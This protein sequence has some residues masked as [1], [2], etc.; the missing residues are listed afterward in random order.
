[1]GQTTTQD[2]IYL[3]K[4][5]SIHQDS[6]LY[7]GVIGTA[8]VCN[9][10]GGN[11]GLPITIIDGTKL[12][13]EGA[14]I[15]N[16]AIYWHDH[17]LDNI[18]AVKLNGDELKYG[19]GSHRYD[20]VYTPDNTYFLKLHNSIAEV[21]NTIQQLNYI[22]LVNNE[23]ISTQTINQYIDNDV[24][25]NVIIVLNIDKNLCSNKSIC[26]L[27][28]DIIQNYSYMVIYRKIYVKYDN[29]TGLLNK[30][31]I[32][33]TLSQYA[34]KDTIKNGVIRITA[35]QLPDCSDYNPYIIGNF[36][37]SDFS[38]KFQNTTLYKIL[39][40]SNIYKFEFDML[41]INI[42]QTSWEQYKNSNNYLTI[43]S[44]NHLNE[45]SDIYSLTYP[46]TMDY[47]YITNQNNQYVRFGW[48][49]FII[50]DFIKTG[51]KFN[52]Y[53]R[54]CCS[55]TLYLKNGEK[56]I[57]PHVVFSR[58]GNNLS[59]MQSFDVSQVTSSYIYQNI[60]KFS[61]T[62]FRGITNNYKEEKIVDI[63][64]SA[65]GNI[66]NKSIN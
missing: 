62:E 26:Y 25:K 13:G 14:K 6:P 29:S 58:D 52:K 45:N 61:I 41:N 11:A 60:I 36:K 23:N 42:I 37:I 38:N 3:G 64:L 44:V 34:D 9:L 18:D 43:K 59:C 20:L 32:N 54:F 10:V 21:S 7:P 28:F 40:I 66:I 56:I 27:K 49:S 12:S 30:Q 47:K 1:M 22:S 33:I 5:F 65:Q 50:N 8:N 48:R 39:E 35:Y 15:F 4:K 16:E 46:Y 17:Y 63:K 51:G 2:I 19:N 57:L 31:L 24:Y 55:I 53:P